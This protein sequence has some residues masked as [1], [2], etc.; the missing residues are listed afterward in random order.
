M[1]GLRNMTREEWRASLRANEH[2]PAEKR[3]SCCP[4]EAVHEYWSGQY[5]FKLCDECFNFAKDE[6]VDERLNRIWGGGT[7]SS[8]YVMRGGLPTLGRRR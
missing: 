2:I 8:V 5:L 1:P 4:A 7:S 3:C 6:S